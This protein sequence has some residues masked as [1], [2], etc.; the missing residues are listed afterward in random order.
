MLT[1]EEMRKNRENFKEATEEV[2]HSKGIDPNALSREEL[3]RLLI[4]IKAS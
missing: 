1:P 2:L 4:E 3:A